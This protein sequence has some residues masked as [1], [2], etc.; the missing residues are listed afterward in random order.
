MQNYGEEILEAAKMRAIEQG[1]DF[2][3]LPVDE[4]LRA[5]RE[6]IAWRRRSNQTV[7]VGAD[8]QGELF[9]G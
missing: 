2:E 9:G 4:M 3:S 5:I 6:K 8:C 7:K 1:M